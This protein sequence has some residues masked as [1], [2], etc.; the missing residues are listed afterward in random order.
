[1]V[2]ASACRYP[3]RSEGGGRGCQMDDCPQHGEPVVATDIHRRHRHLCPKADRRDAMT[4]EE[5][6]A[7]VHP[8]QDCRDDEPPVELTSLEV[9]PCPVCGST[10]ACSYDAE[11]RPL[12]HTDT[13]LPEDPQ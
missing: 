10:G 7:D 3:L 1:V 9:D 11:G 5:F 8:E 13:Q 4:D 2:T 6:W 12:I